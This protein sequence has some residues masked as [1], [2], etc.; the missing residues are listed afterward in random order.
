MIM[1]LDHFEGIFLRQKVVHE[2]FQAWHGIQKF[3]ANPLLHW[4]FQLCNAWNGLFLVEFLEHTDG[5]WVTFDWTRGSFLFEK[6]GKAHEE[7]LLLASDTSKSRRFLYK[8]VNFQIFQ[9]CSGRFDSWSFNWNDDI[10]IRLSSLILPFFKYLVI[11]I[12]LFVTKTKDN[13]LY[14]IISDK[15]M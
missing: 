3:V 8:N 9:L 12:V 5:K 14:R 6:L 2:T 7:W 13:Y 11:F 1:T 10:S 15:L 4:R